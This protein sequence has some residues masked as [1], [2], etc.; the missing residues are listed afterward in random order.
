MLATPL[1]DAP[2]VPGG[3]VSAAAWVPIDRLMD[4]ALTPG[5][6]DVIQ[7]AV[8]VPRLPSTEAST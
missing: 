1:G 5:L 2:P 8:Q 4:L 6:P 3:D 7:K